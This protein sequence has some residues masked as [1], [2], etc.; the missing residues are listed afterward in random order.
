MQL[1]LSCPTTLLLPTWE[2]GGGGA[3]KIPFNERS[4]SRQMPLGR[5]L[6]NDISTQTHPGTF[7][8]ISGPSVKEWPNPKDIMEPEPDHIGQGLPYL[9][10]TTC[11][12]LCPREEYKVGN[13]HGSNPGA[14]V[15]ESGQSSPVLEKSIRWRVSADKP[16]KGMSELNQDRGCGGHTPNFSILP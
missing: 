9:G 11:R 8:C 3:D 10:Q 7:E 16:N 4:S 13:T 6:G 15:L 14:N 1:L 2:M 5:K 12:S